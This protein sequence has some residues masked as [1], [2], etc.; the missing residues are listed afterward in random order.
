MD[1]TSSI[2]EVNK[3][4][5][6]VPSCLRARLTMLS[7]SLKDKINV[8]FFLFPNS[9]IRGIVSIWHPPILFSISAESPYTKP[10]E[11]CVVIFSH[12]SPFSNYKNV[13][14]PIIKRYDKIFAYSL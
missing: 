9:Y 8:R 13:A 14:P 6:I 7:T 11:D 5:L 2:A 1:V 3:P 4:S 10:P 12:G